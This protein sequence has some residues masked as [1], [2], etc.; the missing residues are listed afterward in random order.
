MSIIQEYLIEYNQ[1]KDQ[2]YIKVPKSAKTISM[3]LEDVDKAYIYCT[4]NKD[5]DDDEII[6][7]EVLWLGTGWNLNQEIENKIGYYDFLG[8]Y[9][10]GDFVWHFWIEPMWEEWEVYDFETGEPFKMS[11][12]PIEKSREEK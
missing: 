10:Y 5:D 7:R 6:K 11:T 2:M 8:T 3:I 9:K 12:K 4:V 1:E